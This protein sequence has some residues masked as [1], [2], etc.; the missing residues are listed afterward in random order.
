VSGGVVYLDC[1]VRRLF[2]TF[3]LGA[4]GVGLLLLR[5]VAGLALLLQA[6]MALRSD[7]PVGITLLDAFTAI[8]G[9]LLLAGLWTPVTGTLLAVLALLSAFLRPSDL[10]SWVLLSTVGAALALLGPGGWSVDARLF[11]WRRVELPDRKS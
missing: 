3:A 9:V 8:V 6:M 2:S 4:P 5:V 1:V 7:P 10:L 11:G